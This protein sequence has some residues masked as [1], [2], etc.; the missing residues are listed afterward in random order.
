MLIDLGLTPQRGI[1]YP[2]NEAQILIER[3]RVEYNTQCP[4][5][6]LGYSPPAPA[7]CTPARALNP[8]SQLR[9]VM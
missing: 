1:F 4:H 6:A 2:L 8:V 5:S 7:A 9:A 3:W